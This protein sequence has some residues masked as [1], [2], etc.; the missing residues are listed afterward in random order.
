M[1]KQE[2]VRYLR[3]GEAVAKFEEAFQKRQPVTDLTN[4][5]IK[6]NPDASRIPLRGL[7]MWYAD[8]SGSEFWCL[9]LANADLNGLEMRFGSLCDSSL[10]AAKLNG[11]KIVNSKL[12]RVD[13][14]DAVLDQA[15]LS[16]SQLMECV[17]C[18]TKLGS[19]YLEAVQAA[20]VDFSG[21]TMTNANLKQASLQRAVFRGA[22]LSGANM[23]GARIRDACLDG[24]DLS[25]VT[26]LRLDGNSVRGTRFSPHANDPWH[27]LK[28]KYSGPWFA[29]HLLLLVIFVAG[30]S[31]K[32]LF[33]VAV[34]RLESVAVAVEPS[35]VDHP[36]VVNGQGVSDSSARLVRRADLFAVDEWQV[37]Q[38][39]LG[40]DK[41][42]WAAAIAILLIVYNICRG[43][44]T[45]RVADLREAE[46]H[47][48]L[49]PRWREYKQLFYAHQY[50][51]RFLV[52]IALGSFVY[53][54]APWL[55]VGVHLPK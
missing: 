31:A 46:L 20:G 7:R 18:R 41:G 40:L 1:D 53:H 5:I 50:G 8:M 10:V 30:Y 23:E 52:L 48:Q 22:D 38:L 3:T 16:K 26:G 51:M 35:L 4:I 25:G 12:Y 28:R 54:V 29:V 32:A 34:N 27:L 13:M 17:C 11:A 24:A 44:I 39:L 47:A 2:A 19:A 15:V 36:V 9:D 37:W 55:F 45:L 33:W 14:T 42:V 21:A 49:A 43:V 6:A